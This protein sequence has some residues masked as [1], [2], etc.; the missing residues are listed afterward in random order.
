M[1][2]L[3]DPRNSHIEA[4]LVAAEEGTL[5]KLPFLQYLNEIEDIWKIREAGGY[6]FYCTIVL[7]AHHRTAFPAEA[8]EILTKLAHELIEDA[9]R[10]RA[11]RFFFDVRGYLKAIVV[12]RLLAQEDSEQDFEDAANEWI[13]FEWGYGAHLTDR[14][15]LLCALAL[16]LCLDSAPP[17]LAISLFQR[18]LR[19]DD[20]L[21]D[22][23]SLSSS[24]EPFRKCLAEPPHARYKLFLNLGLQEQLPALISPSPSLAIPCFGGSVVRRERT[25]YGTLQTASREPFVTGWLD[26]TL[27]PVICWKDDSLAGKFAPVASIGQHQPTS[28]FQTF[29]LQRGADVL[30]LRIYEYERW[31]RE[32]IRDVWDVYDSYARAYC[33]SHTDAVLEQFED[34]QAKGI[35]LSIERYQDDTHLVIF[36]W[37]I[38]LEGEIEGVPVVTP[39]RVIPSVPRRKGEEAWD[40]DWELPGGLWKVRVDPLAKEPLRK[41]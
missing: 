41:R 31:P 1:P 15:E 11:A 13:F 4:L 22:T 27:P 33:L 36:L 18:L 20:Q 21:A 16:L 28:P 14:H 3:S 39:A 23:D 24:L 32:T 34:S 5:N 10:V 37:A 30:A 29:A 12:L 17:R 8:Q 35:Q 6:L 26:S 19:L 2:I 9:R 7:L 40:I 25:Q 38:S